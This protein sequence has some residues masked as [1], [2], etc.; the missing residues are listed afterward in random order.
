MLGKVES[1]LQE[2]GVADIDQDFAGSQHAYDV[3]H[4][5]EIV[6]QKRDE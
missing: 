1:L 2:V 5:R 6:F 4:L 3:F